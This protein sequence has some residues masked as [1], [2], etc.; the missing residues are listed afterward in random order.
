[1]QS[2][3]EEVYTSSKR[4]RKTE[5]KVAKTGKKTWFND[6]N[7]LKRILIDLEVVGVVGINKLN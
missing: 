4:R 2:N 7:M 6:L 3:L 5:E 1:M